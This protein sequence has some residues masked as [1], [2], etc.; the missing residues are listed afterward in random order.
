MFESRIAEFGAMHIQPL[1]FLPALDCSHAF[2]GHILGEA[3]VLMDGSP[4]LMPSPRQEIASVT[5]GQRQPP[6]EVF[7][8]FASK[9]CWRYRLHL[10]TTTAI[11]E[12][13]PRQTTWE[14]FA[15][16]ISPAPREG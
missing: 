9:P 16:K 13:A 5:F 12:I 2:I 4:T 10:R 8:S 14:S 3:E 6:V 1:Q 15:P 11:P 7:V